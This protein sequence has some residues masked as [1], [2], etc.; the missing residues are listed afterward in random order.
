[1]EEK[2]KYARAENEGEGEIFHEYG[3]RIKSVMELL[4]KAMAKS[5]KLEEDSFSKQ[6]GDRAL[7]QTR[8]NYYPPCS[9]PD[10]VLG[11]KPH[12]D[13]SGI[14]VLLQDGEVEGLQVFIEDRWVRIPS[15]PDALLVNLGDQMQIMS[16][17]IFK[18]PVHRVVT[19][20]EKMRVSVA[21]LSEPEPEREIGP[22]DCLIDDKKPRLYR[23]VKNYGAINYECYQEGKIALETV[24]I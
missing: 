15:I 6:F 11:L 19:N 24:K 23:N 10:Q 7:M 5:L 18:S 12:T 1:M 3:T 20:S 13:K 22:V 21:T 8:F 16:N 14:T 4:Y 2:Q 17:G 9:R